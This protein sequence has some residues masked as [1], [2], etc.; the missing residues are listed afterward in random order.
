[1]RLNLYQ[2]AGVVLSVLWIAGYWLYLQRQDNM[3][4]FYAGSSAYNLCDHK[5]N[6]MPAECSAEFT[7]AANAMVPAVNTWLNLGWAVLSAAVIWLLAYGVL[8]V[9][10]W[11]LAG[12]KPTPA[13]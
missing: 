1:M 9:V 10:R 13:R 6:T 2:R 4:R 3:Q 12:R 11:V 8:A 5:P 7:E